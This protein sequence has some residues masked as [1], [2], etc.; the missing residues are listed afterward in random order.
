MTRYQTFTQYTVAQVTQAARSGPGPGGR[1][2]TTLRIKPL[3]IAE[4]AHAESNPN[5]PCDILAQGCVEIGERLVATAWAKLGP[6]LQ[7]SELDVRAVCDGFVTARTHP[8]GKIVPWSVPNDQENGIHDSRLEIDSSVIRKGVFDPVL[9]KLVHAMKTLEALNASGQ[10]TV[11]LLSGALSECPYVTMNFRSSLANRAPDLEILSVKDGKTS[12]SRGATLLLECGPRLPRVDLD[13][14]SAEGLATRIIPHIGSPLEDVATNRDRVEDSMTSLLQAGGHS[15]YLPLVMQY[16]L[17]ILEATRRQG[18]NRAAI[19]MY[20]R[21]DSFLRA[22]G[23]ADR[24]DCICRRFLELYE[25]NYVKEMELRVPHIVGIGA[26]HSAAFEGNIEALGLLLRAGSS[27]SE[28]TGPAPEALAGYMPLHLATC[29]G[30][31]AAVS[32]LLQQG[33]DYRAQTPEGYTVLHLVLRVSDFHQASLIINQIFDHENHSKNGTESLLLLKDRSG[34]TAIDLARKKGPQPI[35]DLL[36]CHIPRDEQVKRFF[37]AATLGNASLL[38]KLLGNDKSLTMEV[39]EHSRTALHLAAIKGYPDLI[40]PLL[41]SGADANAKDLRGRVPLHWA[42]IRGYTEVARLL[43]EGSANIALK[44][45]EYGRTALHW[46]AENGH[47]QVIRQLLQKGANIQSRCNNGSTALHYAVKEG[48]RNIVELLLEKG[49]NI[50]AGGPEDSRALHIAAASGQDDMVRFLLKMGANVEAKTKWGTALHPAAAR[51]QDSMVRELLSYGADVNAQNQW[52]GTPLHNAARGGHTRTAEQLIEKGATVEAKNESGLTALHIA[53]EHDM[54]AMVMLLLVRGADINTT[55][56]RGVTA[57]GIAVEKRCV[58]ARIL[59]ESVTTLAWET[60]SKAAL[61]RA[62][63]G[64]DEQVSSLLTR[65]ATQLGIDRSWTVL[66]WAAATG[67]EQI[68]RQA[69]LA[70]SGSVN[71]RDSTKQTP[72]HLAAS[73]GHVEAVRILL[74]NRALTTARDRS[75]WMPLHKAVDRG[76]DSIVWLLLD[77]GADIL[78]KT[79]AGESVMRLAARNGNEASLR[80]LRKQL[81]SFAANRGD[82]GSEFLLAVSFG[83]VADARNAIAAGVDIDREYDKEKSP[84]HVAAI[85]GHKKIASLL[86]DEG[87]SIDIPD[88]SDLK[89]TPLHHAAENGKVG[90]VTLLLSR[91]ANP[92]AT[93]SAR[94]TS[95]HIAADQ[96]RN[97]DEAVAKVVRVL[98]KYGTPVNAKCRTSEYT[99]LHTAIMTNAIETCRALLADPAIDTK[100]LSSSG[101]TPLHLAISR[102]DIQILKLLLSASATPNTFGIPSASATINSPDRD[103]LTLLHRAI[104]DMPSGQPDPYELLYQFGADPRAITATGRSAMDL[105]ID[106]RDPIAAGF[107]EKVGVQLPAGWVLKNGRLIRRKKFWGM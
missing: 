92:H 32:W 74:A 38:R 69:V 43:L 5:L 72:L 56:H 40:R 64:G 46:A 71:A 52:R 105:A 29:E 103:G 4:E 54:D 50:D 59:L 104:V 85:K 30:Q 68:V 6:L 15:R 36:E 58:A 73:N 99:A 26:V 13:G 78:A 83:L 77:K 51:G 87:A 37:V 67:Y 81:A 44:D 70:N 89:Y 33:A 19:L 9:A 41:E 10:K 98:L 47:K 63:N 96:G 90:M 101:R 12:S 107:L 1:T 65:G 94:R 76:H 106:K 7:E 57:L 2:A 97:R 62:A 11:L 35:A 21:V 23:N 42:S 84:L 60:P 24:A 79:I 55:D 14:G 8:A 93:D 17:L 27:I 53:A 39:Q 102:P 31:S 48:A 28:P 22:V 66:H 88:R 45:A 86:L 18:L 25:Q 20:S 16:E 100:A 3:H 82:D 75:G 34:E 61:D 91:G 80:L 95:L 49:A